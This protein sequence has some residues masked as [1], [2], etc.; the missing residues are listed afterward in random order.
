MAR[1]RHAGAALLA[2]ALGALAWP[3]HAGE[4]LTFSIVLRDGRIEPATLAV[5]V[6]V[7]LRLA[8]RN[9]GAGPAEFEHLGLRVEKVLAPGAAS[10]LVLH[11]LRPGRYH[12][13]DE[14]HP[15]GP[16]LMLEAR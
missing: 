10:T 2:V 9:A 6:G 11:P 15:D 5:P 16:G 4:P 13:I 14:F 12:C 7:K 1:G 3:V 8:V